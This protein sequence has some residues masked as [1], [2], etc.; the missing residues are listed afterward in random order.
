MENVPVIVGIGETDFWRRGTSPDSELA[1]AIKAILNAC[2]D[3]G[4][5]PHQIDGFCSFADNAVHALA[6]QGALGVAQ[7]RLCTMAWGGG[8]GGSCGALSAAASAVECGRVKY[9][10]VFRSVVQRGARFGAGGGYAGGTASGVVA[11]GLGDIHCPGY[12]QPY[13]LMTPGQIAAMHFQRYM[14]NY[15]VGT[16]GLGHVATT[17]RDNASRNPRALMRKPMTLEDHANSRMISHPYRLFDFCQE[18]DGACA[19]I[20]TSAE[21]ARDLKGRAVRILARAE[22][23]GD[24]WASLSRRSVPA[25]NQALMVPEIYAE[26]GIGPSDID[27]AQ[28]YDNYSGQ[29]LIGLEEWKL[30]GP[31][32]AT[33]FVKSGAIGRHGSL[34]VNTAGGLLSE[35]YIQG[36]NLVTEGVRQIRGASTSQVPGAELALV[37]GGS[38]AAPSSAVILARM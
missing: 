18:N 24:Q 19:L 32:E 1:L 21:R 5:D 7:V 35:G 16:E 20:V 9:A 36:L 28:I 25:N 10:V 26:A 31:G 34:P 17:F 27:V 38:M 13:G 29:V 6:L 2:G 33:D 8:G 4:I 14:Y 11:S 12:S 15:G 3:A 22:G 23:S 30:C 37:T